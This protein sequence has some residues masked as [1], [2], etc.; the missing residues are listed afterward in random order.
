MR[1]SS[2]FL[3]L[4]ALVS[5]ALAPAIPASTNEDLRRD[6]LDFFG[7]P[8]P[9]RI[10]LPKDNPVSPAKTEL[11]RRLFNDARLSSDGATACA[12]C[13]DVARGGA[14]AA[15][16][17]VGHPW[18]TAPRNA[19]S[20]HNALLNPFVPIDAPKGDRIAP[21]THRIRAGID[22]DFFSNAALQ[23]LRGDADL[24]GSFAGAFPEANPAVTTLTIAMALEAYL[25]TLV[26][27]S[28]FD[29]FLAGDVEALGPLEKIGL[30]SFIDKGCVACHAGVTFGATSYETFG[31]AALAGKPMPAFRSSPLRNVASTAPYFHDGA[32]R[33]LEEA[34]AKMA[35]AQL[36][37]QF[38]DGDV[39]AITAFLESLTGTLPASK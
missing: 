16:A 6:A 17:V 28:P 30:A 15:A 12:G 10:P 24:A 2:K 21:V 4:L 8:L 25:S 1:G 32:V 3:L 36:G 7:P 34:V 19:P 11:G 23:R 27:P 35:A 14:G 22:L 33:G 9:E 5:A 29:R 20:V 18:Q 26:T 38:Q 13:H 37:D 31:P 39:K